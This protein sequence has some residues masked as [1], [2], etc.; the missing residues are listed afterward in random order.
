MAHHIARDMAYS[1]IGGSSGEGSAVPR[2]TTSAPASAFDLRRQSSATRMY[3]DPPIVLSDVPPAGSAANW[4]T[5][6][7]A[8]NE[9]SFVQQ[10]FTSHGGGD[11]GGVLNTHGGMHDADEDDD[12]S[13]QPLLPYVGME[14]DSIEDAQKFYNDYAFGTGFG[15]RIAS[16]KNSQKKGPQQL[17]KR[18]FQCVHA[19]KPETTCETSSQSEGIAAGG[20][21]SS[22]QAGVEMDVTVKRQRNR[23]MR[24]D[25][26]AHMIVGLRGNKWVVT[27][28]VAQHTHPLMQHE[29]IVRFYR[30][31]RKIPEEDYQ[32]L[33]TMHDVNLSTTNCMGMLGMVHGGDRRKLPYVKR[34]V[35]N[36]RSKLRQNQSFQDMDMTV[37]YFKRRQAENAQFY[38]A[39]E[40]D[41]ERNEVTTLFWVDGRTR[42]LYPK[43]KDCVFFDTTF[44]TN[45][46]NLPFA[47]IVGVNNHLQTVLLGCALVPNEQIETFKWVFQHWMIAMN[48]EHPLNLMTNQDKA[49]ETAIKDVFPN[50]VHRCCKWHVQRKAREKL[51]R[52]LSMDENFE[53]VFYGVINDSETVDEFE[54]NWQHMLHC[55][56]LVDNRHLSNMWRK[57]ETWAPAYFR[58]N[59]FP[60]TST[61]GRSEGLNSYF[62]TFVNPQDSVWR[63]VQQYEVLQETMLDREDNQAFIG[64]ETTAPLY[65]RYNFERQAVH[66]YTRSVFLKFQKEVMASTGF[67]M[68][69][70]PALDNASVRFE[71]HSNYFENPRIFS[72]NV[73]LAEEKFECSCNCFEM[74]GIICAHIIRKVYMVGFT[75]L[76]QRS[77]LQNN[78]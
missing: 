69:L 2:R 46:Y 10:P 29:E 45:R 67:I 26:K 31:H 44:C 41:K 59:F 57:R 48:N 40:V 76:Q 70:A 9:E 75:S 38:Y 23:I 24:Y 12:I 54:E 50:T 39:T 56:E 74:N 8:A 6:D 61:T 21:S 33:M 15:S 7:G 62:K 35:S 19:G 1:A 25:C 55:F 53:Q 52:I 72:V 71:L 36:A 16:S 5:E 14:F 68:N 11:S 51:G 60:F 18:V 30:S 37:A 65:S 22:K 42:A 4:H 13:S 47:P 73:V 58:K 27:Y 49:M 20:S 32:L 43:Y 3:R 17:I 63:F 77:C 66:F 34:D 64:H 78:E 28:F